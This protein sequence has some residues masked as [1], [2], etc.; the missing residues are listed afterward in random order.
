[1]FKGGLREGTGAQER[2]AINS[3]EDGSIRTREFS[4]KGDSWNESPVSD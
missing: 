1:M 3:R 4:D 2:D